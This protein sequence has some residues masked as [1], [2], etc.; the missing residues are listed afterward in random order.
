[1]VLI[2]G[3]APSAFDI[4]ANGTPGGSPPPHHRHHWA[5]AEAPRRCEVGGGGLRGLEI[6][7]EK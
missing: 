7:G 5:Q 3:S 1:M 2:P 6:G 4:N